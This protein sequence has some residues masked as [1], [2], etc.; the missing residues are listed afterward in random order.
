MGQLAIDAVP[1]G[2][3]TEIKDADGKIHKLPTNHST[4]LLMNLMAGSYT[5]S[6]R[7]SDGSSPQNLSIDVVAQ[8][9]VVAT[10]KFDSLTAD[11]YFERSSW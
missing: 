10:A 9:T 6:I 1:W 7:N 3:V 4:P 8:Q 2:E 11:D 5:V